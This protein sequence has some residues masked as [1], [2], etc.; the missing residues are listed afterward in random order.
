MNNFLVFLLVSIG[1]AQNLTIDPS[2]P[3]LRQEGQLFVI[4]IVAGEPLRIFV[5]GKE[6]AQVDLSKMKL[7][8]RR[9]SPYPEKILIATRV[10]D[11]FVVSMPNDLKKPIDL[12][13][14]TTIEN[15]KGKLNFNIQPKIP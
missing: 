8:V 3:G 14:T 2:R 13:V 5:A 4:Q 9:L 1:N 15:K 7:I 6:E 10:D 12:E 11:H